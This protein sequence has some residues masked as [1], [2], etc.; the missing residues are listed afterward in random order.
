M[1]QQT[2]NTT[3]RSVLA[4]L[5]ALVPKRALNPQ[6]ALRIAELQANKLL[7]HFAIT[8]AAV[9]EEIISE[10]PRIRLI[11]EPLPVSGSANWAS[12]YWLITINSHEPAGRQRFSLVHEF[13]HVLDHTTKNYLY[14]DRPLQ[15]AHQQAERVA[16]YFAACLLMPKKVVVRLWCEGQQNIVELAAKLQVSPTALRYRLD[17]LGLTERPARCEWRI[18]ST[19]ARPRALT[20]GGRQ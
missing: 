3:Q 14:R 8:A 1:T 9:P 18:R 11:R 19:S 10:L 20:I 15:T 5:R 2:I 6:E 17:Q 12:G 7:E 13:K 16:D 4:S